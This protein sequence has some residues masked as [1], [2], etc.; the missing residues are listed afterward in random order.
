MEKMM[1]GKFNYNDYLK[2]LKMI[3]RMGSLGGIMKLIP[4]MN[5]MTKDMDL[6]DK[7]LVFVEAI[8]SSMTKQ[9]RKDPSLIASSSSRRRR[10]ASGSG[11]SVTEVNRL[12]Q[13]LQQTTGAMK[14]MQGMDPN[15]VNMKDPM[16]MFNQPTKKKSAKK[17]KRWRY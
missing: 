7:Q 9:E 1:S 8:I 17:K 12:I 14:R 6:D 3:K 16:S 13:T 4:G 5:K 10:I 2:Q 15:K 11:R